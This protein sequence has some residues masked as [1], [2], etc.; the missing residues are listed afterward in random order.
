MTNSKKIQHAHSIIPYMF[1]LSGCLSPS[2]KELH[3]LGNAIP[4]PYK[5]LKECPMNQVNYEIFWNVLLGSSSTWN[6]T[7]WSWSKRRSLRKSRLKRLQ[8][9]RNWTVDNY[10]RLSWTGTISPQILNKMNNFKGNIS[11][12]DSNFR[13]KSI[14]KQF[15]LWLIAI[16]SLLRNLFVS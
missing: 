14:L 12:A 3:A 4:F 1:D 5:Q 11:R 9:F 8:N 6:W 15:Q 13:N 2:T 16:A 7:I 10:W